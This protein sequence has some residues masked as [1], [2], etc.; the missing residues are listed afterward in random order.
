MDPGECSART[1]E[2]GGAKA[3]VSL[4][5]GGQHLVLEPGLMAPIQCKQGQ[6]RDTGFE[7]MWCS[8]QTS[9]AMLCCL[10]WRD[11]LMFY[12]YLMQSRSA[13]S[14]YKRWRRLPPEIKSHFPLLVN[15]F[16]H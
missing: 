13:V 12:N 10:V 15:G 9:V 7:N 4:G 1:M 2:G 11:P 16:S 14:G 6:G 3:D 8:A 5:K